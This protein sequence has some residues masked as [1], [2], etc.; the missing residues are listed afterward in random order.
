MASNGVTDVWQQETQAAQGRRLTRPI[1]Y[2]ERNFHKWLAHEDLDCA[3]K[4][5]KLETIIIDLTDLSIS[6]TYYGYV[7]SISLSTLVRVSE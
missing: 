7:N 5:I 4:S 6:L 2:V 1:K 3:A